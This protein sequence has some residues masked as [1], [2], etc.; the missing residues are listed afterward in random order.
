MSATRRVRANKLGFFD[1]KGDGHP[2]EIKPGQVFDVPADLKPAKW[3]DP[4]EPPKAE[5]PKPADKPKA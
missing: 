3:F 1:I 2:V 5:P 4:V